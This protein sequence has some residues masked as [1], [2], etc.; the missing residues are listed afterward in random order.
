[1]TLLQ[2]R[3]QA[4]QARHLVASRAATVR[5]LRDL[6]LGL[7]RGAEAEGRLLREK[8]SDFG[9]KQVALHVGPD[10]TEAQQ[11]LVKAE[12]LFEIGR[13]ISGC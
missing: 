11:Y 9:S 10:A 7:L 2:R 13:I 12:S 6:R 5:E 4:R 1:M 8:A 3:R